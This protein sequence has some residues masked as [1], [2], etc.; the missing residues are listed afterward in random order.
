MKIPDFRYRS[1]IT[2]Q[3]SLRVLQT[4]GSG[5]RQFGRWTTYIQQ[6]KLYHKARQNG[7]ARRTKPARLD[8]MMGR[9]RRQPLHVDDELT[10]VFLKLAFHLPPPFVV[11]SQWPNLRPPTR[12]TPA[13]LLRRRMALL[14]PSRVRPVA[15]AISEID[16]SGRSSINSTIF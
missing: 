10:K 13:I 11:T 2:L 5:E 6:V 14:T 1:E 8:A 9:A 4:R 12:T 7:Q 16:T 15:F 3:S